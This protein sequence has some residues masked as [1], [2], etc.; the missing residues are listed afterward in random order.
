M[1]A[2][3]R[4]D[5][6]TTAARKSDPRLLPVIR[7]GDIDSHRLCQVRKS[8]YHQFFGTNGDLKAGRPMFHSG[9]SAHVRGEHVLETQHLGFCSHSW[10]AFDRTRREAMGGRDTRDERLGPLP[11]LS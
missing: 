1:P 8:V 3:A 10:D 7:V 11:R 5:A 6:S 4:K 9:S 2:G